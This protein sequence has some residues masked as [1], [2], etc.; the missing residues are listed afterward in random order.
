MKYFLIAGEASG[1]LHGSNLMKA[2]LQED[3][4]AK[5]MFW[6]GDKMAQASGI[7]PSK[8]IS[9]LAI[10]GFWEVV[11][12]IFTIRN[13][14]KLCKS[15][16]T[17]FEPDAVIFI[18]YS[19]FNLRIAP[20]VKSLGIKTFYYIAPKVWAWNQKRAY[21]IKESIDVLYSI[22]PFEKEFFKKYDYDITYIGNPLMDAIAEFKKSNNTIHNTDSKLIGML[23]GSRKQEIERM[24]PTMIEVADSIDN[25]KFVI[26]A[27]TNFDKS[28]YQSFF[29][30]KNY[31]IEFDNTYSILSRVES[32]MVT[33]GTASLE[34]AL[35]NIPHVVCYKANGA[36][37]F[38][39]KLVVKIKYISL[40]N[41]ILDKLA[42]V[43]L[44]Q[45]D[46]NFDKLRSELLSTIEGGNKRAAILSD[47]K[48]LKI[49]VGNPGAS[50]RA[51]EDIF[52]KIS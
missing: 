11:T 16:I 32:A 15:Q 17:D 29:K 1:D 46:M 12:N 8:H 26:A 22:L 39:A 43:E 13:N 36:S 30:K 20:F 6:G 25:Y 49:M 48:K 19:G 9:E 24:L 21:K 38:I 18:D 7:K 45:D 44:I 23:P 27:T 51:A 52:E 41:L 4:A 34:T 28:Y 31:E 47:Y 3:S 33:S 10:M 35:F 5:F 37:Y 42:I 2:I 40:I 50:K 14:F